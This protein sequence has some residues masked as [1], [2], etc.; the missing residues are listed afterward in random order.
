MTT[1]ARSDARPEW[2]AYSRYAGRG[3]A[4]GRMW[5]FPRSPRFAQTFDR[6]QRVRAPFLS[7]P[8][9]GGAG[10][11]G[12]RPRETPAVPHPG[13]TTEPAGQVSGGAGPTP[14]SPPS[15][16]GEVTRESAGDASRARAGFHHP[17]A[18]PSPGR[19]RG[20]PSCSAMIMDPDTAWNGKPRRVTLQL[21]SRIAVLGD[22]APGDARSRRVSCHASPPTHPA[23]R[24]PDPPPSDPLAPVASR[25]DAPR[26]TGRR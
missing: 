15:Q 20:H 7:P 4:E 25:R 19:G 21:R 13:G 3:S 9:E 16:G 23:R 5:V 12:R 18:A 22:R 14:P 11:V 24:C 2:D 6:L 8:C 10:G 17:T 1:R 26:R